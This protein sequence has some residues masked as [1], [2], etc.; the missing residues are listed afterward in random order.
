MYAVGLNIGH[1]HTKAVAID[2]HGNERLMTPFPSQIAIATH[3]AGGIATSATVLVDRRPYWYGW[4]ADRGTTVSMYDQSRLNDETFL[5]ALTQA[6]M[7]ELGIT[8]NVVAY[9][10]LPA[11]W[12]GKAHTLNDRIREGAPNIVKLG[13]IAE[14]V[15][16]AYAALLDNDGTIV[17]DGL[18]GSIGIID[19]GGGTVDVAVLATLQVEPTSPRTARK[20]LVGALTGIQGLINSDY[21]MDVSLA[22]V[23]QAVRERRIRVAGEWCDLPNGWERM[24]ANLASDIVV[25]LDSLWGAAKHLD[26]ILV[27]GGGAAEPVIVEAIQR[28]YRHASMLDDPQ[29]A[30]ARGCARRARLLFHQMRAKTA[31]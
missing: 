3:D 13:V 17:A 24:M 7:Q 25:F 27:A 6:S 23:D 22:T 30:I 10:C 21:D 8:E 26:R 20:G 9:S 29:N 12:L 11:T 18:D 4:A 16:A 28:K 1:A 15:A 19:I 31:A 14:P 2:I 5:P